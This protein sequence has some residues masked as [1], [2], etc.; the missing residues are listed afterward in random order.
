M[1]YFQICHGLEA[2]LSLFSA[3][4]GAAKRVWLQ[5]IALVA[6]AP[7][8][9]AT[10]RNG[11]EAKAGELE[12]ALDGREILDQQH[13]LTDAQ[14]LITAVGCNGNAFRGWACSR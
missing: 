4:A 7:L 13:T 5:S 11:V 6:L 3:P 2:L 9:D 8:Q 12:R 1:Q 10:S 14:K